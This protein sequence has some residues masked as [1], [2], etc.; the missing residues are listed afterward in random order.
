ML[1][2]F[3]VFVTLLE[4]SRQHYIKLA[5]NK[6]LEDGDKAIIYYSRPFNILN[7]TDRNVLIESFVRLNNMQ[8]TD[9]DKGAVMS[10]A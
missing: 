6:E 2:Y 3:Q 4:I 5:A 1:F 8:W 9:F 10:S 7:E